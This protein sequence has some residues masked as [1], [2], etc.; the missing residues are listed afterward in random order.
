MHTMWTWGKKKGRRRK[1]LFYITGSTQHWCTHAKSAPPHYLPTLNYTSWNTLRKKH[2][3][4]ERKFP[5]CTS[6]LSSLSYRR[7]DFLFPTSRVV[8][9]LLSCLSAFSAVMCADDMNAS[10]SPHSFPLASVQGTGRLSQDQGVARTHS[11]I[12][13]LTHAQNRLFSTCF[14]NHHVDNKLFFKISLVRFWVE[15]KHTLTGM[16]TYTCAHTAHTFNM[17]LCYVLMWVAGNRIKPDACTHSSSEVLAG[18]GFYRRAHTQTHT[19]SMKDSP[20]NY[21]LLCNSVPELPRYCSWTFYLG[22]DSQTRGK[23]SSGSPFTCMETICVAA[24]FK[25]FNIY[26]ILYLPPEKIMT[27]LT[28][29]YTFWFISSAMSLIMKIIKESVALENRFL[30]C[31]KNWILG[32]GLVF[33]ILS[34]CLPRDVNFLKVI[35]SYSPLNTWHSTGPLFSVSTFKMN[36]CKW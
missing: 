31:K 30:F 6:R 25:S 35:L 26:S 11:C 14:S 17:T 23:K 3:S 7:R 13:A 2:Q 29:T 19:H 1:G 24:T 18:I 15:K 27:L 28:E 16:H 10:R 8:S 5:S 34:L 4:N 12:H 20:S 33:Q 32:W 21:V 36:M 9:G 22:G